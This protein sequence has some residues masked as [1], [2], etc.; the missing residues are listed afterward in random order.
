MLTWKLLGKKNWPNPIEAETPLLISAAKSK[1][2]PTLLKVMVA[3]RYAVR[4][5]A[6]SIP[7]TKSIT[8]VPHV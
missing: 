3:L 1:D 2:A 4:G 8:T 5:S 6:I 7:S